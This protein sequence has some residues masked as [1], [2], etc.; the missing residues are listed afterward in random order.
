MAHLPPEVRE[1]TDSLDSLGNTTA[2]VAKGFAIGS[3]A[4]TALALFRAYTARSAS[5]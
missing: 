4:L 5:P 3:A 2:A 1:V